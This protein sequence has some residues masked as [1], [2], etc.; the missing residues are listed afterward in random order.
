MSKLLHNT[1]IKTL[2]PL[3]LPSELKKQIPMTESISKFVLKSRN[4]IRDIICGKDK[5]LLCV[6]GPCS[7]HDK[8]GAIEYAKRLKKISEKSSE[9][10]FIVMRTYFEKP[11]T[12]VGWKGLINDPDLNGTFDVNKGL[13]MARDILYEINK[14]GLPCS[15]EILDS[16]TPQYISDFITWGA[17]G[18]RTVESQVHRQIVSGLSMP[19]GFKNGTS[20]DHKTAIE[21]VISVK[22]THCFMGISESGIPCICNTTGNESVHIILRGGRNGPNYNADNIE[23]VVSDISNHNKKYKKTMIEKAIMID[24]SHANSNKDHKKQSIVFK[25]VIQQRKTNNCIKGIMLESNIH[26]GR[27]ALHDATKLKYGVSI[28][29]ACIDLKETEKLCEYALS[30]LR[31]T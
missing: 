28:T 10:L 4:T 24:C 21:A 23:Q 13:Y 5:R 18:A 26:E 6:I 14:I 1:N 3:I 30:C 9:S 16:I 29:D 7:I 11:R 22:H 31:P 2:K 15:Y 12:T 27:Q 25:N 8:K 19:V 17:I 20:G